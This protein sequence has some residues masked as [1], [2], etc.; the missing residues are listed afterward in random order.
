MGRDFLHAACRRP[1][2]CHRRGLQP[3]PADGP[4]TSPPSCL[5]MD[6]VLNFALEIARQPPTRADRVVLWNGARAESRGGRRGHGRR[7]RSPV[8]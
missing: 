6:G 1:G 2:A 4:S 3:V 7:R 8:A 5:S